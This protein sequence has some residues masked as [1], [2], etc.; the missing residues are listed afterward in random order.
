LYQPQMIDDCDCVAISEIEIGRGDWSIRRK[1]A[2]VPL[3]PQIPHDLS[4]LEPGLP[5]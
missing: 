1:P 5:W 2:P 4:R 3:C